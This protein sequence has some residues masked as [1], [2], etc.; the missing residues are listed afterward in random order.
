MRNV[1]AVTCL[2][3]LVLGPAGCGISPTNVV[4]TGPA[5]TISVKA[6]FSEMYLLREGRLVFTRVR[7]PSNSLEDLLMT[8]FAVAN[9]AAQDGDLSGIVYQDSDVY[10]FSNQVQRM[11][12][13][14]RGVRMH[15]Y[16]SGDKDISRAGLAQIICTARLRPEVW[17]VQLT[18]FPSDRAPISYGKHT[19]KEYWDLTPRHPAPPS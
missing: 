19:C 9:G 1:I 7:V 2:L 3:L 15:V 12:P 10:P 4:Q 8:L 16:V 13:G 17:E 14:V 18:Q 5:P 6:Q 11:D